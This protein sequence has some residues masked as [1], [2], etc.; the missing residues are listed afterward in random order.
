MTY[1]CLHK[2]VPRK[3]LLLNVIGPTPLLSDDERLDRTV[4][5]DFLGDPEDFNRA[6]MYDYVDQLDFSS[7]DLVQ[8]LRYS[9]L[10]ALRCSTAS[11]TIASFHVYRDIGGNCLIQLVFH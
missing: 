9:D 10:T 6:V 2:F 3:N 5:G 7:K 11:K 4:V 8:A 1:Q